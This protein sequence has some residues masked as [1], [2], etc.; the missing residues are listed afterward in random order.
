[1]DS[2][3]WI[4]IAAYNEAGVI[5]KV[6]DDLAN[7]DYHVLV[8]NDGSTDDTEAVVSRYPITVISHKINLGQ[9]AAL[10]TGFKY[11]LQKTDAECIVTFDADGQHHP[12]DIQ[13][14]V[15]ACS[16]GGYQVALGSRFLRKNSA[17]NIPQNKRVTLNMAIL[18]TRIL[19]GLNLT[20]TH[21]GLRGFT[22]EAA[23]KIHITQNR[24]AHASEILSQIAEE[25][26]AYVEVPVTVT[27]TEYSLNKGQSIFN[28]INI[29]WEIVMGNIK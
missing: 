21:N 2:K 7:F 8:V 12:E 4:V 27:Y 11:V 6:L 13:K 22:R 29:L 24:M 18:L 19:T 28:G 9:G 17:V 25:K 23:A 3:T 5:E 26:L 14:L 10:Q 15:D 1:M 16:T 20:D